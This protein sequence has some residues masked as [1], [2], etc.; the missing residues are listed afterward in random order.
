MIS[1]LLCQVANKDVLMRQKPYV[2]KWWI[3]ITRDWQ[4]AA[5]NVVALADCARP[6]VTNHEVT[7]LAKPTMFYDGQYGFIHTSERSCGHTYYSFF[8]KQNNITDN[9]IDE[10]LSTIVNEN[11]QD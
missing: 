1:S 9:A 10:R 7:D 5:N 6:Q 4:L 11:R 3:V 2:S 8:Y